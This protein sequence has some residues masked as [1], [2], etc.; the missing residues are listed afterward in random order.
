M[1]GDG[2]VPVRRNPIGSFSQA[3]AP[4]AFSDSGEWSVTIWNHLQK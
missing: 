4:L 3:F 2:M 1:V